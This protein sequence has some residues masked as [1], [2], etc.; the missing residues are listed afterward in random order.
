M[1]KELVIGAKY[2]HYSGKEYLA[3]GFAKHSET[4]EELIIY[5]ALYGNHQFWARPKEMF[6]GDVDFNGQIVERFHHI[7]NEEST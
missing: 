7:R 4:L 2:R 1:E 6:L 5:Q 3:I